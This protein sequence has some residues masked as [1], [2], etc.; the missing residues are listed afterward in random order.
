MMR[1]VRV[2]F[3]VNCSLFLLGGTV[4]HH[5][6][7]FEAI[8]PEFVVKFVESLY[9]DDSVNV[10]DTLETLFELYLK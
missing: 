10:V 9:V 5:F 3:G 2:L 4:E 1:F 7:K 6:K 8:D